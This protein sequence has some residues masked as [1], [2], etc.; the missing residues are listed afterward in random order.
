MLCVF[1]GLGDC[2]V[3]IGR[4]FFL[5]LFSLFLFFFEARCERLESLRRCDFA[6]LT[7][8]PG[9]ITVVQ[10]AFGSAT[11]RTPRDSEARR[12]S[13]LLVRPIP[14]LQRVD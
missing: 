5:L 12:L 13:P 1:V 9:L 7:G 10:S 6:T 4:V 8:F 11:G 3:S 2:N 14:L